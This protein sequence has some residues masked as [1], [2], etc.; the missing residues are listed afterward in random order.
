MNLTDNN[1]NNVDLEI[2]HD[3]MFS[4]ADWYSKNDSIGSIKAEM[5]SYLKTEFV[6]IGR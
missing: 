4:S 2:I 3:L 5:L 1:Y 6:Y